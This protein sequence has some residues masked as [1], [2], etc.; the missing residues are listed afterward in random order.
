[1]IASYVALPELVGTVQEK[2]MCAGD[3]VVMLRNDG[4]NPARRVTRFLSQ[5]ASGCQSD[6]STCMPQTLLMWSHPFCRQ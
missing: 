6:L 5:M 3:S 2:S 1:M 4:E